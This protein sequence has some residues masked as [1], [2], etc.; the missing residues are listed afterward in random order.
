MCLS[1]LDLLSIGRDCA[2]V[3]SWTK[4]DQALGWDTAFPVPW[5]LALGTCITATATDPGSLN[6]LVWLKKIKNHKNQSK[7][8]AQTAQKQNIESRELG[9]EKVSE[10][11][12][13]LPKERK[14]MWL[15]RTKNS[16]IFTQVSLSITTCE[17]MPHSFVYLGDVR[18]DET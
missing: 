15:S 2:F 16:G 5:Y 12:S 8:V 6:C 17:E 1:V 11:Q 13:S 4:Q 18:Q 14:N 10:E 9:R 7:T 3:G